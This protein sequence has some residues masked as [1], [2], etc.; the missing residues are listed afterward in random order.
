MNSFAQ[1]C[2]EALK[3]RIESDGSMCVAEIRIGQ[4]A[5][6][7]VKANKRN[8]KLA[9]AKNLLKAIN[10]NTYLREK[11]YYY[12]KNMKDVMHQKSEELKNSIQGIQSKSAQE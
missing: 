4:L 2:K 3:W 6:S 1:N 11:F 12:S 9:A 7:A 10:S 8:A 5:S